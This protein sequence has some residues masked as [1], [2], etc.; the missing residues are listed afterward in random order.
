MT[1]AGENAANV[2]AYLR[3]AQRVGDAIEVTKFGDLTGAIGVYL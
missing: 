2:C 1:R 3:H